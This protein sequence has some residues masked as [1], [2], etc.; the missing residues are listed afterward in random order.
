MATKHQLFTKSVGVEFTYLPTIHNSIMKNGIDP[1]P[2]LQRYI[3][4]LV[5]DHLKDCHNIQR[6]NHIIE[7]DGVIEIESIPHKSLSSL[8]KEFRT[9]NKELKKI[10]C[11]P[12]TRVDEDSEGGG[13]IHL[14]IT[15]FVDH[16]IYKKRYKDY[17][18]KKMLTRQYKTVTDTFTQRIFQLIRKYPAIPWLFTTHNDNICSK[19]FLTE[20]A[21]DPTG[22]YNKEI[23]SK[24]CSEEVQ[25]K[26]VV[27]K[28]YD[29]TTSNE[30]DHNLVTAEFRF[31]PMAKTVKELEIYTEFADKL[32]KFIHD[33]PKFKY[34][35][36]VKS[37][38]IKYLEKLTYSD[39]VKQLKEVCKLIGFDYKLI[40]FRL[41]NLKKRL[42]I[43]F[44]DWKAFRC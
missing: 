19:L 1:I 9:I 35:S 40:T 44:Y 8:T 31:F 33:N 43:T 24:D 10:K 23:Y 7:E 25:Q 32:V 14:E 20:N 29:H 27:V 37:T 15:D 11:L 18:L 21:D 16:K 17:W 30:V 12:S 5:E 26:Y 13:H 36:P 39:C 3:S 41:P 34:L 22:K 28:S 4:E 6:H 2:T 38:Y 42:D